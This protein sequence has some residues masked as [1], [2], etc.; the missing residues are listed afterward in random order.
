M[1]SSGR[2]FIIW[3]QPARRATWRTPTRPAADFFAAL[4][5]LMISRADRGLRRSLA[6]TTYLI[7]ASGLRLDARS[8]IG[9]SFPRRVRRKLH[10]VYD[11]DADRP[12][13]A[14]ITAAG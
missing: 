8:A 3:E 7:D 1:Q 12:I 10:V 13:Y 6:D 5:A 2:G 11:P 4:L 14:A 9:R